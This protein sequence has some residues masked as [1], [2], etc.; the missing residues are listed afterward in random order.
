[1]H[2]TNSPSDAGVM[3]LP[4]RLALTAFLLI[5]ASTKLASQSAWDAILNIDPYPSPYYS[6]WDNNPNIASLTVVNPGAA[7]QVR[8]HFNVTNRANKV[9]LSGSSD[10]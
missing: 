10:P 6:D 3:R 5:S 9:V 8:I 2:K 7:T 4:A 1:M